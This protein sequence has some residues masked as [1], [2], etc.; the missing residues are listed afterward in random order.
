M[1]ISYFVVITVNHEGL[2]LKAGSDE[3]LV[4]IEGGF[5]WKTCSGKGD[6]C[7]PPRGKEN[8]GEGKGGIILL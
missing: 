2:G 7:Q 1:G 6:E 4:E 3:G 5:R 8:F